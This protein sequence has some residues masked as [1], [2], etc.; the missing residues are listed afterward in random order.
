MINTSTAGETPTDLRYRRTMDWDIPP[1]P[2]S[3]CVSIFYSEK[4]KDLEYA[5]DDGFEDANPL[6]DTSTSGIDFSCSD[7]GAP[8][9]VYD[10]GPND[11]GANFQFLFMEDD[12]VTPRK[13]APGESFEFTIYYGAAATKAEA[14]VAISSVGAEVSSYGYSAENGCSASNDGS[15]G[16]YIFAFGG[17]G[18]PSIFSAPPSI[19]SAPTT[20]TCDVSALIGATLKAAHRGNCYILELFS[21]GDL[22]VD[23]DNKDCVDPF[24]SDHVIAETDIAASSGNTVVVGNGDGTWSGEIDLLENQDPTVTELEVNEDHKKNKEH[25]TNPREFRADLILPNGCVV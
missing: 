16:V 13:L 6:F 11:H 8:C 14:D 4:P 22:I 12:G 20:G 21:G 24:V 19:S 23:W 2:F 18:A 17:V 15:P 9:P 5:T 7:G 1:T 25:P 10:S 3:E